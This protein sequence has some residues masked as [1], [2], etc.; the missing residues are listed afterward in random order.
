MYFHSIGFIMLEVW[1]RWRNQAAFDLIER[2]KREKGPLNIRVY[3]T[4]P[5]KDSASRGPWQST[6]DLQ[7]EPD[8]GW[9][10]IGINEQWVQFA[11]DD[12]KELIA[13]ALEA[14]AERLRR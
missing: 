9:Y 11:D 12:P 8:K 10:R 6:M 4:P 14:L 1:I 5:Q 13:Y 2:L 3:Y 7:C